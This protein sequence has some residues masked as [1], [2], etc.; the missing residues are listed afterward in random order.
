[1]GTHLAPIYRMVASRCYQSHNTTIFIKY[2]IKIL[3]SESNKKLDWTKSND[4]NV[5]LK[6]STNGNVASSLSVEVRFVPLSQSK[7]AKCAPCMKHHHFGIAPCFGLSLAK[8]CGM[9][10]SSQSVDRIYKNTSLP[11]YLLAHL[12]LPF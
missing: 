11:C 3:Y 6:Y 1:M 10:P 7:H 2:I 12:D 9:L 5:I 8:E 4:H